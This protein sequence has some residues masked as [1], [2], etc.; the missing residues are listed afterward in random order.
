MNPVRNLQNKYHAKREERIAPSL[1]MA[2]R[3]ARNRMYLSG[4]RTAQDYSLVNF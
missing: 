1:S 3:F 4:T 2:Q